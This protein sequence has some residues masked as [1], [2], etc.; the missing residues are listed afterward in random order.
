MSEW[1]PLP[2][3][4]LQLACPSAS[5]LVLPDLFLPAAILQ[6]SHPLRGLRLQARALLPALQG[7]RGS[8]VEGAGAFNAWCISSATAG[9]SLVVVAWFWGLG[10]AYKRDIASK[11]SEEEISS[12]RV[13]PQPQPMKPNA[14]LPTHLLWPP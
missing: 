6:S 5:G 1:D 14:I 3:K 10:A 12:E 8:G 11:E 4:V 7:C 9:T 2:W 13:W